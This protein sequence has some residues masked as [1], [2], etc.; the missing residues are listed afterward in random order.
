MRRR[1]GIWLVGLLA[2]ALGASA[3]VG[4]HESSAAQARTTVGASTIDA[5]YSCPVSSQHYVDFSANA[6]LPPAQSKPRPGGLFLTTGVRTTRKNGVTTAVAQAALQAVRNSL[7]ID[8]RSCRRVAHQIPLKPTGLGQPEKATPTFRGYINQRCT[9]A[10]RVLFRLKVELTA[11]T[12]T[13]AL[14][15][16]R[17]DNAKS[18]PIAFYNW[19][20]R[21]VY[22]YTGASCVDLN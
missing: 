18:R 8:K 14:L 1:Q 21:K 13:H 19:T 17:N 3:A 4:V 2:A 15:A 16:V 12:P 9:T 11:G 5:T 20:A 22:A 7:R 6:T 10:P